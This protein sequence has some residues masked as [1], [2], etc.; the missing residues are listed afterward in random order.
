MDSDKLRHEINQAERLVRV[1]E[2]V[3]YLKEGI[4]EL[5]SLLSNHCTESDKFREDVSDL[6]KTQKWTR[7]IG[8]TAL[9]SFI[10][11]AVGILIKMMLSIGGTVDF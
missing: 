3:E 11:G 1:E 5:K 7:Y 6:K 8:R 9:G 2:G 10:I 4:K